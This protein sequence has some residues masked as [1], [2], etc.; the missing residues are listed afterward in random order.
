MM[1]THRRRGPRRGRADGSGVHAGGR[2]DTGEIEWANRQWA[3]TRAAHN[4]FMEVIKTE[5]KG[6]KKMDVDHEEAAR[7]DEQ[8]LEQVHEQA[9]LGN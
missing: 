4:E 2:V 1:C 9:A 8:E 6:K 3:G 7:V 5:I